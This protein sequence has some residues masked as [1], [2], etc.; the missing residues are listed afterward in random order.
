MF[1]NVTFLIEGFVDLKIARRICFFFESVVG[2][3]VFDRR[4]YIEQLFSVVH[5]NCS[6]IT[7]RNFT[8]NVS[9]RF[10]KSSGSICS[11]FRKHKRFYFQSY[12]I[13]HKYF[14]FQ[15]I[16]QKWS[17]NNCIYFFFFYKLFYFSSK[18]FKVIFHRFHYCLAQIPT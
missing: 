9:L 1:L 11:E 17:K 10:F 7:V 13:L 15:V 4:L 16:S 8:W 2:L 5:K 18:I 12:S 6:P 3:T 14:I